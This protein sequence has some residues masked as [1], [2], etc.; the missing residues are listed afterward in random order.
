MLTTANKET[1]LNEQHSQ[2]RLACHGDS[3]TTLTSGPNLELERDNIEY[4]TRIA[5]LASNDC[6]TRF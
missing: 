5:L 4:S 1:D 3:F 2:R 6:R